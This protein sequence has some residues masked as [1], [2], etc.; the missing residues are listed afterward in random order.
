MTD[1]QFVFRFR[2]LVATTIEEHEKIIKKDGT[3]WW[4]WWKRPSEDARADVWDQ[5]S[6]AA[7]AA[8]IKVILFDSGSGKT[9][10]AVVVEV[11]APVGDAE[12]TVTV[13]EG[14]TELVPRYYRESP[15]SRAW[16]KLTKITPLNNFWGNYSFSEIKRLPGYNKAIL[17]RFKNKKI[18]NAHELRGMDTTIWAVRPSMVGD[19]DEEILLSVNAVA[20]AVSQQTVRCDGDAILHITDMHF[21]I[22][23]PRDQHVWRLESEDGSKHSMVEA[24]TSAIKAAKDI[25]IGLVIASG[26]FTY[27][28]SEA[29][30]NEAGAAMVR[31]LGN[32]DLSPDHLVIIPGNHDIQ[33]G[34]DEE[35]KHDAPVDEAPAKARKNYEAFYRTIM[36]HEPNRHLAMGRRFVLPS[37]IVVET[38]A[39]NS[40]SLATGKNFLAGMGRIDEGSFAEVSGELGWRENEPSMA[41][42]LLVIHHHLAITENIEDPNAFATGYGIAVDAVRVQRMAAK[43]NVQLAIHGHKHRAFIWRSTVYELPEHAQPS[44]RSGE[45]SIVGGGSAGSKETEAGKNYFNVF[46]FSASGLNLEIFKAEKQGMFEKMQQ[47]HA[48]FSTHSTGGLALGDWGAVVKK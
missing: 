13:P 5:L 24:I 28:G 30:Y 12:E 2:D 6:K 29:E 7:Q 16:M 33:W 19:H 46:Q 11:I 10:E 3:V 23:K 20:E 35:Y 27:I 48:S 17:D 14:Q 47:F 36:R 41:F 4:G 38:C 39:L 25:K 40:S 21:A 26:D 42:R 32:L 31:L 34:T 8:P 1:T 37:G 9:Y 15:F 18:K 45:L 43:R 22:G 44:H